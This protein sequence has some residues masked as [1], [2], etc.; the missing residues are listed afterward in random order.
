MK[1]FKSANQSRK[2]KN[3]TFFW[4]VFVSA[5]FA[6]ILLL[7]LLTLVR[8]ELQKKAEQA[9]EKIKS[10]IFQ[11]ADCSEKENFHN[12]FMLTWKCGRITELHC[13]LCV[14]S[15]D[16]LDISSCESL[17]SFSLTK[18]LGLLSMKLPIRGEKLTKISVSN[19]R[20]SDLSIFSHLLNLKEL[21]LVNNKFS[22]TLWPLRNLNKLKKLV[23]IHNKLD[24]GLEYL[25][26]F[27]QYFM[28]DR[29]S[30]FS[31]LLEPCLPS[32]RIKNCGKQMHPEHHLYGMY[33]I[34]KWRKK[35]FCLTNNAKKEVEFENLLVQLQLALQGWISNDERKKKF[36]Q[37]FIKH[38]LPERI[39]DL[40]EEN[41]QYYN[42][43]LYPLQPD[44]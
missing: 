26:P 35:H 3:N 41:L 27:V 36:F 4:K 42:D 40:Q 5:L 24:K 39:L 34:D 20:L 19:N 43:F 1:T 29:D 44:N 9:E 16:D 13:M 11:E 12:G 2:R 33:E 15:L 7:G 31:K 8:Y 17:E 37:I 6:I 10:V 23:I 18:G 22:G 21:R 30:E 25:P 32:H 38:I 14:Y 28:C